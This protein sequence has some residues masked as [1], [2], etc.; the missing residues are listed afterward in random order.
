MTATSAIAPPRPPRIE[1][2]Q[3]LGHFREVHTCWLKEV[4][5]VLEIARRADA[6]TW[7][8]W[9]AIQ[10]VN[11]GFLNRFERERVAVDS[12]HQELDGSQRARLWAAAELIAALRWQLDHLVGACHRAAE[13]ATVTLKLEAALE[14]WCR[15][16]EAALG[17]LTWSEVPEDSRQLLL[18][19]DD[20]ENTHGT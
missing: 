3:L 8:R 1:Q 20:Q 19:I 13:F 18:A 6:G 10:Y 17:R 16:V 7:T 5:G 12:L 2:H 14:H 15:E 4:R 11:T 9:S